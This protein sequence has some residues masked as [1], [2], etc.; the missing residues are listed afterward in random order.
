[1]ALGPAT[2]EGVDATIATVLASS[3]APALGG[4]ALV[5]SAD[6][7]ATDETS[8]I[9]LTDVMVVSDDADALTVLLVDELD[10]RSEG[11]DDVQLVER[12]V[13]GTG[14]TCR[15]FAQTVVLGGKPVQASAIVC[16]GSASMWRVVTPVF[17]ASPAI[18]A[19]RQFAP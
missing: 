10:Q 8:T 2:T 3:N 7:T 19:P 14:R 18:T 6:A 16:K 12:F 1:M 9:D 11:N 15:K 5:G 17:G 13:D 4:I